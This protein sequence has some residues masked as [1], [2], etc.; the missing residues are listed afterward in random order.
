MLSDLKLENL[1]LENK[2]DNANLKVIDFGTSRKVN[3][4]EKLSRRIG[5]V[6]LFISKPPQP[7][8]MAPEVLNKS[9]NLKCDVWSCG[10]IL[11]ILLCGYPPFNGDDAE[12]K[13]RI[14]LGKVD[15]DR[16]WSV[17]SP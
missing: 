13:R 17:T 11:Y 15:F 6:P 14:T 12:I 1:I 8:Y 4:D 3:P 10:V 9:Y 2:K 16:T 5:T 7:Y